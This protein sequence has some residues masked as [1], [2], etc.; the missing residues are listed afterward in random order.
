MSDAELLNLRCVSETAMGIKSR[1]R[2]TLRCFFELVTTRDKSYGLRDGDSY[3]N[4][5]C[6]TIISKY[7][8]FGEDHRIS[9]PSGDDI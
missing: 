8:F 6:I 3:G 9:F 7:F 1:H 5:F 2:E 4:Y